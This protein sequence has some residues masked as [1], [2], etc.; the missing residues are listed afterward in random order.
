MFEYCK[1]LVY[2]LFYGDVTPI[3]KVDESNLN[4]K[5]VL[6]DFRDDKKNYIEKCKPKIDEM[7][8]KGL[9]VDFDNLTN[10]KMDAFRSKWS[11]TSNE[12]NDF[13]L[14][15]VIYFKPIIKKVLNNDYNFS[16]IELDMLSKLVMKYYIIKPKVMNCK[17]FIDVIIDSV[18][19]VKVICY[20]MNKNGVYRFKSS[21]GS[22]EQNETIGE[23]LHREIKEELCL[24]FNITRYKL[25]QTDNYF[26]KYELN[27]SKK[28]FMDQFDYKVL[29][30]EITHVVL[31]SI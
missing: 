19:C 18:E 22:V 1:D 6:Y 10:S 24:S 4:N 21:K 31:E 30:P 8:D 23:A 11:L 14:K 7:I 17:V 13:D 9:L 12:F 5:T 20:N 29:D 28:E 25:I 3:A 26:V 16:L 2:R 15:H 27:L